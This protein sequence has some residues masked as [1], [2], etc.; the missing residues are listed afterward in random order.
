MK[1]II[2][3]FFLL[4][5][6]PVFPQWNALD[7]GVDENLMDIHC[8]TEDI[9]VAVGYSG[10]IVKTING[11]LNWSQKISGSEDYFF[12]V[13]FTSPTVGYICGTSGS[14]LKT[15]NGGEDWTEVASPATIWLT[16]MSCVS[17]NLIYVA[18]DGILK[19]SVDGATS[20]QEVITGEYVEKI[21][22]LDEL[23]GYESGM[24]DLRKTTDGGVTW[25]TIHE[26]IVSVFFIDENIGFINAADGIYKTSDGG[27]RYDYLYYSIECIIPKLYAFSENVGWGVPVDCPLNG[28]PCYSIRGEITGIDE[29]QMDHGPILSGI[30]FASPTLGYAVGW[31]AIYK[32]VTGLGIDGTDHENSFK[33]YPNPASDELMI[34]LP[35]S[36]DGSFLVE[37]IDTS[38]KTAYS[39]IHHSENIRINLSAFEKG[40]YFI[41]LEGMDYRQTKKL[42]IN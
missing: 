19:K 28:S 30:D 41:R 23:T 22:F 29:F 39:A 25:T 14:I 38:G 3:C 4:V 32:N 21:Q 24:S 11:G 16:D 42:V 35:Y 6:F 31:G 18:V 36:L 13:Q 26:D 2:T 17:D 37:I 7:S 33:L 12:K 10:T 40:I 20:F 34:S 1:E 5:F 8:I 27:I 15:V 9:V